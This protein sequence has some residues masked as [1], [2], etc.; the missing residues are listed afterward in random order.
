MPPL[1]LHVLERRLDRA[2]E[3]A[4]ARLRP[5]LDRIAERR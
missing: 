1:V 4:L 2:D 3:D 5:G